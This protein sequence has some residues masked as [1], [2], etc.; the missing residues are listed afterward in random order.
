MIRSL[1][2][3]LMI[4][5]ALAISSTVFGAGEKLAG[6]QL[7]IG[8]SVVESECIFVGRVRNLGLR[9]RGPTA[10]TDYSNVEIEVLEFLKGPVERILEISLSIVA[11]PPEEREEPPSVGT[12]YIMIGNPRGGEV[13]QI[14]QSLLA[15]EENVKLVKE[16]IA[17]QSANKA[18]I[19]LRYPEVSRPAAGPVVDVS[20]TDPSQPAAGDTPQ[21]TTR[22][23][24]GVVV[25]LAV[26]TIV[27]TFVLRSRGKS[28][29][30]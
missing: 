30:F 21:T 16:L 8:Q 19:P 3:F 14:T 2:V 20:S 9:E 7:D 5:I 26:L 13:V 11:F 22:S 15:S 1:P 24:L 27:V 29:R 23:T 25:L 28:S 12:E 6:S 17:D 18:P 10:M 4:N